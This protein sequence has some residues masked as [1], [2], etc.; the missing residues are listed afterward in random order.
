MTL[1]ISSPD[2]AEAHS[3]VAFI[4]ET[5]LGPAST[6]DHHTIPSSTT[7]HGKVSGVWQDIEEDQQSDL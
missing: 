7:Q 4:L 5:F 1:F 6:S 2:T 3:A